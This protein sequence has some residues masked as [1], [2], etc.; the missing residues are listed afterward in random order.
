MPNAIEVRNLNKNH[1]GEH[2][3]AGV[4]FSVPSGCLFGMIGA[5]GAGK[6]TLLRILATLASPDSGEIVIL[7]QNPSTHSRMIRNQMGYMPQRFSLYE[8]LSV[9]ENLLFFADIFGVKGSERENRIKRLLQFSL[10]ASFQNRR[11]KNLSG[12]M[13]QKLAL[14]CALIHTPELLIL[15]EP[16]TGV[17][18]V[19]RKEFW[20]ILQELKSQGISILISTPYMEEAEYCDQL[21]FMHKG[22]VVL[23]GIPRQL[24]DGYPVYL[25]E[26]KGSKED[27]L[28]YIPQKKLPENILLVYPSLGT[29]HIASDLPPSSIHKI[30]EIFKTVLPSAQQIYKIDPKIEDLFF[31][32][33]FSLESKPA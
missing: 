10:L 23:E 5:D 15:D 24:L 13:K 32:S 2:A 1:A 30:L 28:T 11:A 8:D 27:F 17:D 16:T 21:I 31:Y 33:L 14:S 26:I 29:L 20:N 9:K 4:D 22:K 6:T 19:S 25:Y 12:G 3:L 18:P 7:S